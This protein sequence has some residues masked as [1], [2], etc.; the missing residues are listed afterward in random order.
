MKII[1]LLLLSM[2]YVLGAETDENK[3]KV[4]VRD[5]PPL[6]IQ[7]RDILTG[8]DIELWEEIAK[9][10]EIEYV[11]HGASIKNVIDNVSKDN[12]SI[13][14]GGISLTG[15]RESVIDFTHPYMDSKLKVMVTARGSMSYVGSFISKMAPTFLSLLVF[16]IF[17]GHVLWIA[18]HGRDAINDKYYP[19][20]LE[21]MWLTVT[22]MTT[23]GYGDYSPHK[24][25]GKVAA[26]VIMF[27][28]ITFY[29]WVIANMSQ[30]MITQDY[31][32][33]VEVEELRTS[34]FVAPEYTTSEDY[35][36]ANGYKYSTAKSIKEAIFEIYNNNS[37]AVIFDEAVLNYY[38]KNDNGESFH[39]LDE[40]IQ[41]QHYAIVLP[42]GSEL[43]EK[44]NL[45][46]L[47]I[48]KDGTYT[49]IYE[50]W[51]GKK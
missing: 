15:E 33:S 48:K 27:V 51:L 1:L 41:T 16:I 26:T 44:I 11:Y 10:L 22:T 23:V 36:K 35:L 31:L 32:N 45:T 34:K 46:I 8:F 13:A 14:I 17:C 24:W 47:Q 3:L 2:S 49:K 7:D 19:G 6:V 29:G 50:K 42:Q 37:D 20:V 25:T 40:T 5:F 18:E 30:S 21:G 28:G 9:R 4:F 38:L 39:I 43:R 12:N